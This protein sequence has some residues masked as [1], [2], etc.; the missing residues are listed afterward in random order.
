VH[1]FLAALTVVLAVAVSG[2][3][4]SA[5]SSLTFSLF[6]RYLESL[7]VQAGIPGKSAL[8]LQ[9]GTIVW[10]GGFGRADLEGGVDARAT[11]PYPI[12]DLSQSIG[13]TLLL[14]ECIDEG[15][16]SLNDPVVEWFPGFPEPETRIG[17]LLAHVA[18]TGV[19]NYDQGRFA[20]LTPVIEACGG[21]P[22]QRLLAEEIFSRLDLA[23]S[24]PGTALEAPTLE[25]FDMFGENNLA[26]YA[27]VLS[28]MAKPYRLDSRGR[29]VRTDVAL[30]R[31]NAATGI[32]STVR[33]LATFDAALPHYVL[34]ERETLQRAWRRPADHLPAGL[35]W[36]VQAYNG[37]PIVWQFGR[38]ENAYSSLLV[39]VP[40]RGLTF[41]LLANSDA[42]ATPFARE[43]W[44]ITA[45]VFAR[46]FLLIYVP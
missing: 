28:Q 14:K 7:R 3:R 26:R 45:S 32:V 6:E 30:A 34:L 37:E 4:T 21:M 31:V 38:I 25:D 42:L 9:T 10:D 24:V 43:T 1:R 16:G 40:N 8:V 17:H 12:G 39:K 33:D 2:Q 22:Y 15:F 20:A 5:Q 18:P 36:F 46:L 35:G 29:H 41:I 11:T 13:A 23:H 27:S 19:F 44:D